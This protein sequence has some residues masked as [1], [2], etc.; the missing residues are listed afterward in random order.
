MDLNAAF[1]MSYD[2]RRNSLHGL[3]L[4]AKVVTKQERRAVVG[5]DGKARWGLVETGRIVFSG[6]SRGEHSLELSVSD[7]AR[8]LAH[9]N[10]Y[11]E[12]SGLLKPTVGQR[13]KF[14]SAS[15]SPKMGGVRY[16]KVVKVG[17]KRAVIEF[18][19]K[20]GGHG[21]ATVPFNEMW[22]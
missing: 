7:E 8:V 4:T 2:F 15:A 12:A 18:T 5:E 21:T 17:S 20:H 11:C 6:G 1:K 22:F 16:G 14:A 10:G 3:R 13:V 9:W 19:Y